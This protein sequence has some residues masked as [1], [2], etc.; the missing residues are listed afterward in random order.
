MGVVM[1]NRMKPVSNA[2]FALF[3]LFAVNLKKKNYIEKNQENYKNLENNSELKIM[4]GEMR[5]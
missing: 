3:I 2:S 1:A 4:K 5:K